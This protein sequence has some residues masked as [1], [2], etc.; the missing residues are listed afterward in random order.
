MYPRLALESASSSE[1][2]TAEFAS[3]RFLAGTSMQAFA[4]TQARMVDILR[5]SASSAGKD[6]KAKMSQKSPK[7]P[8]QWAG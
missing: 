4:Q 7:S 5:A 8:S 1:S 6:D 2:D 3:S